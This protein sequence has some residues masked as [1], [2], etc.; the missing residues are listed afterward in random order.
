MALPW[1][2]SRRFAAYEKFLMNHV[3]EI[4]IAKGFGAKMEQPELLEALNFQF[5]FIKI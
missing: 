2:P 1:E 5:S 4:C 3:C